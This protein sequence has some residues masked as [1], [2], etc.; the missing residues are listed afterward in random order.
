M[1]DPD[2]A[3][4]A[5]PFSYVCARPFLT[6]RF[7][8]PQRTLGWSMLHPGFAT[9]S[10]VVWVEVRN[11]DL[12][13]DVD[14]YAFLR[15]RLALAGA[16]DAL[17]FMTS[18]DISRHHFRRRRVEDIEASC[19]TTVGLSNAERIGMRKP[20]PARAGTINTLVHVS[21]PLSDGAYVE[22]L[23]IA[24]QAR[25]AAILETR[26]AG[27]EKPVTGTGTDCVVI[28]APCAAAPLCCA[29][30]HTAVGEAIGGAV[31][32]ATREGAEAWNAEFIPG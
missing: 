8:V 5:A 28:A 23:S 20:N 19:L 31:Y 1:R 15:A 18:R 13:P 10:D 4:A 17:A 32:D 30:L 14:A 21:H 29:G 25:T 22:A 27:V 11:A 9:V 7:R 3:V 12:G 2:E 6:V 26:P 24:V 16:G